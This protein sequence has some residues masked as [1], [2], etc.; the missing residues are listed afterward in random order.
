MVS[1]DLI[2]FM[3]THFGDKCLRILNEIHQK[4]GIE[5]VED[6]NLDDKRTFI[7]ELQPFLRDK[8][9]TKSEVLITELMSILRV[10]TTEPSYVSLGLSTENKYNI[11]YYINNEGEKKIKTTLPEM[12][13]LVRLYLGNTKTA[14]KKGMKSREIE[15]ITEK[16]MNG[17]KNKIQGVSKDIEDRFNIKTNSDFIERRMKDLE[18]RGEY[19]D[20]EKISNQTSLAKAL[21]EYNSKVEKIFKEYKK[22]FIDNMHKKIYLE[23]EKIPSEH[24]TKK[25]IKLSEDKFKEIEEAYLELKANIK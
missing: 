9:L 13:S 24:I 20:I 5:N 15:R 19:I 14:M 7:I 18:E 10:N 21:N 23:K 11:T 2:Q 25:T 16:V 6:A 3:R 8:S 4:I 22:Q 17:I 12:N 1:E